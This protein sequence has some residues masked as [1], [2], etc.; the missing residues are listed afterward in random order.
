MTQSGSAA[1]VLQARA[2]ASNVQLSGYAPARGG[3]G[4]TRGQYKSASDVAGGLAS[5][6]RSIATASLRSDFHRDNSVLVDDDADSGSDNEAESSAGGPRADGP[7]IRQ[8]QIDG[9]SVELPEG[10][11]SRTPPTLGAGMCGLQVCV[12]FLNAAG[13][14]EWYDGVIIEYQ[15]RQYNVGRSHIFHLCFEE[16]EHDDWFSLPDATVCFSKEKV[17]NAQLKRLRTQFRA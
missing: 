13:E 1:G 10:A 8:A 15:H 4:G 6:R 2:E 5:I 3:G 11:Y 16:D 17:V 9:A 7:R 14:P 12:L